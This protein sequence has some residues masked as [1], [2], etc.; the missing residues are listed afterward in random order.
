MKIYKIILLAPWFILANPTGEEVVHGAADFSRDNNNLIINQH[1]DKTIIRWDDF[2]INSNETTK[3]I[4]PNSSSSIL[5]KVTG[6]DISKI[7]GSLQSNG[8]VY[9]INQKGILIGPDG[10]INTN[11]FIASTLDLEDNEYI[12]GKDFH[13]TSNLYSS[14]Q[15]MGTIDGLDGEVI[16]IAP[17]IENFGSIKANKDKLSLLSSSSALLKE[18]GSNSLVKTDV[19]FIDNKGSLEAVQIE[20]KASNG[21]IYSLAINQEGIV[22]AQGIENRDGKVFLIAD[23]RIETSGKIISK[24]DHGGIIHILADE[25]DIKD[26]SVVDASSNYG[27]SKILIG[28][29]YQGKNPNIKNAINTN[30]A[31]KVSI[32]ANTTEGDGGKIIIF[33]TGE[34]KCHANEISA[35]SLGSYGNGGFVEVSG[36]K[37]LI[38]SSHPDLHSQNGFFGELFLDPGAITI[39]HGANVPPAAGVFTD[40]Y[41]VDQ[42]QN[43]GSL[44]ISTAVDGTAGFETATINTGVNITWTQPTTF[45][46]IANRSISSIAAGNIISN[47]AAGGPADAIVFV[48]NGIP[49]TATGTGITLN[50]ITIS[51]TDRNISLTGT[52][53]VGNNAAGIILNIGSALSTTTGDITLNGTGLQVSSVGSFENGITMR[54]GSS[55][56]SISGNITLNGLSGNSSRNSYGVEFIAQTGSQINLNTAGQTIINGTAIGSSI[57]SVG[58]HFANVLAV[59]VS[60]SIVIT[61]N[62]IGNLDIRFENNA[63]LQA[64][65]NITLVNNTYFYPQVTTLQTAGSLI[66]KPR[67]FTTIGIGTGTGAFSMPDLILQRISTNVG[68]I[69]IGDSSLTTTTAEIGGISTLAKDLTVYANSISTVDTIDIGSQNLNLNFSAGA[70]G[71]CSIND[72]LYN[73]SLGSFNINGNNLAGD[74]LTMLN[75][76]DNIWNITNDNEGFI[77]SSSFTGQMDFFGVSN[78]IGGSGNDTFNFLGDYVLGGSGINGGGGTNTIVGPDSP[79][80]WILTGVNTGTINP[81]GAG[82]TSFRNIQ[83]ITGGSSNDTVILKDQAG[84]TGTADGGLGYNILD[85]SLYTTVVRVNLAKGT[86]TNIG[87]ILNFQKVI[88]NNRNMELTYFPF[89]DTT[90]DLNFINLD[91]FDYILDNYKRFYLKLEYILRNKVFQDHLVESMLKKYTN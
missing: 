1:Q 65:G 72:F 31:E 54:S 41:I 26:D 81:N 22:K 40:G 18:D 15:N 79:T 8:K 71:S 89:L 11:G 85:Y 90:F 47:T 4:Q 43:F 80:V 35:Q 36:L 29:D 14:I 3:F 84:L 42:L 61:G 44:T 59:L 30:V 52:G 67:T 49:T 23:G 2:S 83:N 10:K 60:G 13:F 25:I 16:L 45:T 69:I 64:G 63:S 56:N 53:M 37:D 55:I 82:P 58:I 73:L 34:T 51:A 33:S 12:N 27:G 75:S 24:D 32:I 6:N 7:Y 48:A 86:A 50:N 20:V 68:E 76:G 39:N 28:G 87:H 91:F 5:N 38:I 88:F 46:L 9:L 21:N 78:L 74:T 66:I 70:A 57:G 77:T 19:S 62:S 17:V